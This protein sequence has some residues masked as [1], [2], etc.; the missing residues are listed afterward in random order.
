MKKVSILALLCAAVFTLG[1]A[2]C[3]EKPATP[4][5]ENNEQQPEE[6]P[7]PKP[8]Q[9]PIPLPDIPKDVPACSIS[10][11]TN[12]QTH[13]ADD[14]VIGDFSGLCFNKDRTGL[15]GVSN[16]QGRLY[17]INFDGTRDEKEFLRTGKDMEGVTIDP[18]TGIIY[19]CE[20]G[21]NYIWKVEEYDG[22]YVATRVKF[23][24][25]SGDSNSGLEAITYHDGYL[26]VANQSPATLY[27]YSLEHGEVAHRYSAR[28]IR[29]CFSD[30]W[31]DTTNNTLWAVDAWGNEIV[32]FT[33]WGDYI[34]RFKV[35]EVPWVEG[36][37]ID[38]ENNKAW[39]SCDSTG[40]LFSADIVRNN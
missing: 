37:C 27:I 33:V 5:E 8:E 3:E 35:P 29:E 34:A 1:M 26:Y 13:F 2:S 20:E 24:K 28:V 40:Q 18:E 39:F 32:N 14:D 15:I 30:L 4:N 17:N 6:K 36:I 25:T 38:F 16:Y 12:W 31:F 9:K 19:V 21:G 23:I 11:F 7:E 10:E 22:E